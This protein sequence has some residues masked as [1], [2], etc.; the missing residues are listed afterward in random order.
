MQIQGERT[1]CIWAHPIKGA[2]THIRYP[3]LEASTAKPSARRAR[4]ALDDRAITKDGGPVKITWSL[5]QEGGEQLHP[6]KQGWSEIALPA[7]AGALQL[8]ISAA[9]VGRRHFCFELR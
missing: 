7:S 9:D 8:S 3:K 4:F 5:G 6:N 1:R 2:T